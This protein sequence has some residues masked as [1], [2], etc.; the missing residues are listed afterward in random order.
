MNVYLTIAKEKQLVLQYY[1]D[2]TIREQI[3]Y[4]I[5]TAQVYRPKITTYMMWMSIKS[6]LN[7]LDVL[8]KQQNIYEGSRYSKIN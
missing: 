8:Y 3:G 2:G 6:S 7:S 4:C 1:Q 5:S